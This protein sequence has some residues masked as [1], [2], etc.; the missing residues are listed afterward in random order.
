MNDVEQKR[1]FS[2]NL[3]RLLDMNDLTQK[4]VADSIHVS[5]QTFNTWVKGIAIPRMGKIQLLADYFGIDKSDLL[6][7]KPVG[8]TSSQAVRINV[9][10]S[11]PAGIPMEAIEDIADW[12]DIPQAWTAGGKE[13]FGLK[14]KGDSMKPKF[15]DGDTIILRKTD[16]CE[17]GQICAVYV[18]GYNATLKKVIITEQPSQIILQPL[19]ADYDPIVYDFD[20][21]QPD[22]IRICGVVV[23]IRRSV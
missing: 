22:Y 9:Y 11:I 10:G 2:K 8:S 3:K 12:E 19:N 14:V 4:E 1:I 17:S 6:D 13:Y 21:E 5:A 7:D 15:E 20:P 16:Q 18:N 23:E